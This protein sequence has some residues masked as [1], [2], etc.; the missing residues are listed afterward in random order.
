MN[1]PPWYRP[2]RRPLAETVLTLDLSRTTGVGPLKPSLSTLWDMT[3]LLCFPSPAFR[4][5]VTVDATGDTLTLSR[6]G[7]MMARLCLRQDRRRFGHPLRAVCPA[8]GHLAYR[9]YRFNGVFCC[10]ECLRVTYASGS[11]GESDRVN[12]RLQRLQRR[13]ACTDDLPRHRGRRKITAAIAYL[14]LRWAAKL[15]AALLRKLG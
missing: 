7:H 4:V 12:A 10:G 13:L 15:P 14:D 5:R 3:P 6:R 11:R 2:R 1:L 9:L 8:C